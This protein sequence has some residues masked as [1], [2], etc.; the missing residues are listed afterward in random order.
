MRRLRSCCGSRTCCV[1]SA[2]TAGDQARSRRHA[3]ASS[4]AADKGNGNEPEHRNGGAGGDGARD[5]SRH[6]W[7]LLELLGSR[8]ENVFVDEPLASQRAEE[9]QQPVLCGRRRAIAGRVE[10]DRAH[11][12]E[13]ALELDVA[14]RHRLEQAAQQLIIG[15]RGQAAGQVPSASR[16]GQTSAARLQQSL[17]AGS[18]LTRLTAGP[19][20][21]AGRSQGSVSA[22]SMQARTPPGSEVSL[23]FLTHST[24]SAFA[25]S[26]SL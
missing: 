5:A 1:S 24:N 7:H 18:S 13:A 3:P 11:A 9:A 16:L 6:D 2:A 23:L 8:I 17:I 10:Q 15:D 12:G 26:V 22:R 25:S 14:D 21:S 4:A 20:R 19:A